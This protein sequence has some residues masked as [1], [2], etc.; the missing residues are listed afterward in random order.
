M[1]LI[2]LQL[3]FCGSGF[4]RNFVLLGEPSPQVYESAAIAAEGPVL[5]RVGPIHIALARRTFDDG[6]HRT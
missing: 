4:I 3:I 5:R 2:R 6:D 1:P